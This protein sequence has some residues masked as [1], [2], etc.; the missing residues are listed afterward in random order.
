MDHDP[1]TCTICIGNDRM[2]Y[3]AASGSHFIPHDSEAAFP[4]FR[5][6]PIISEP[7]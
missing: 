2:V 5:L 1:E 3:E 6:Y 4:L 7:A